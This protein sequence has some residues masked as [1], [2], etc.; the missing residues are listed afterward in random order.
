MRRQFGDNFATK[1]LQNEN[2]SH[3]T[4]F[5]SHFFVAELSLDVLPIAPRFGLLCLMIMLL[6]RIF[7]YWCEPGGAK[8]APMATTLGLSSLRMLHQPATC[9]GAAPCMGATFM[10]AAPK[11]SLSGHGL[12]SLEDLSWG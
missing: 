1:T 2:V 7:R 6:G 5:L 3:I 9:M 8:S 12:C 4:R 10:G 11:Y